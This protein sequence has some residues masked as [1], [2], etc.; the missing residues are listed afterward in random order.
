MRRVQS[1]E[2]TKNYSFCVRRVAKIPMG[3]ISDSQMSNPICRK[4]STPLHFLRKRLSFH[5]LNYS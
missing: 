3:L 2:E 5:T 1:V 4:K